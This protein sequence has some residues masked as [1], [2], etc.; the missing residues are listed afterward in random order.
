MNAAASRAL[1]LSAAIGRQVRLRR[2]VFVLTVEALAERVG[3]TR[4]ELIR[5]EEGGTDL[6]AASIHDICI[7]LD[8]NLKEFFTG[9]ERMM[10]LGAADD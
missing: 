5:V 3:V 9:V 8:T 4:D 10:E 6:S 7:A 1:S 2:Q